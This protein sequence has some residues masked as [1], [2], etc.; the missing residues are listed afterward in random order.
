MG[1][2]ILLAGE[3]NF[4]IC[5]QRGV[6]GCV[7]PDKEWNKAEVIAGVLSIRPGDLLFFYVKNK[8]VYGVWKVVGDVFFDETPI[9]SNDEQMYPYRFCFEPAFGAF[10]KPISLND[11]LDLYDKHRIW[12]FD[13]N[14][15]QRKN[16][17]KIT[18]KEAQELLRLLLRNNPIRQEQESI[19]EPYIPSNPIKVAVEFPSK[20]QG[21]IQYE[22][23]LNAWFMDSLTKG[24]LKNILGDYKEFLNLVPTTFNKVM[25]IFLTHVMTVG[26]IDVIYKYTCIELKTERATESDL[27]QILRY[28][29]WLARKLAA[30][31]NEMIQSVLV[32]WSFAGNV[33]EY[34]SNRCRIEEKTIRL[35]SYKI[36]DEQNG[37]ELEEVD[38]DT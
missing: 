27:T 31:D 38:L 12:T 2:H 19:V 1:A 37:I 7:M 8:G 36:N 22:G 20:K 4:E 13:L 24:H 21:R 35:V 5:I 11:I 18:M 34:V 26:S 25:D 32:A 3:S 33:I 30:G 9:W 23:W 10:S 14:P 6:Y 28:E 29:D 16:Q 17:Y 15:V